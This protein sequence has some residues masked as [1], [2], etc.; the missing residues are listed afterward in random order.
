[1]YT[2]AAMAKELPVAPRLRRR[3]LLSLAA[4]AL[5]AVAFFVGKA[6]VRARVDAAVQG[7][8]GRALPSFSL[9]RADGKGSVGDAEVRGRPL[10]LHFFRSHCEVCEAEAE[11][12]RQFEREL[13]EGSALLH[14]MTDR[15]LG[16][17]AADTA[18]T[19][20][21]KAFTAPVVLADA[22]FVD[23]FHTAGWAGITPITYAADSKGVIRLALR[24]RQSLEDLRGALRS[25]R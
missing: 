17:P 11:A 4:L 5:L 6:V 9:P 18:A 3:T 13:P 25:V 10:V 19:L 24:G 14:V 15:V 22:A 16:F 1:M 20:E 7:P 21:R 8:V 12:W 2:E 23:A